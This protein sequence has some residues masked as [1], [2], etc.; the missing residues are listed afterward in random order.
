MVSYLTAFE[1]DDWLEEAFYKA[2]DSVE[3]LTESLAEQYESL[4]QETPS[5]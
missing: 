5:K 2:F 3:V 1:S 4:V